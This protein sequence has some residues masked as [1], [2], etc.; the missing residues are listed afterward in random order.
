MADRVDRKKSMAARRPVAIE[1][2]SNGAKHPFCA[3]GEGWEEH[4]EEQKRSL[5]QLEQMNQAIGTLAENTQYLKQLDT[6]SETLLSAATGRK[7]VPLSVAMIL[8]GLMGVVL[9]I[10]VIA[11]TKK[12]IEVG[13]D[14]IKIESG[15]E[16][17]R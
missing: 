7:Q 5:F 12:T 15:A 13:W 9:M 2:S 6:I 3:V 8:F 16:D 14:R 17:H 4:R 1:E 10:V 11:N